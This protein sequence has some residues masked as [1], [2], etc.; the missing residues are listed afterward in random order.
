M[1]MGCK[2]CAKMRFWCATSKKY[3]SED[4]QNCESEDEPEPPSQGAE[5][6]WKAGVWQRLA[7]FLHLTA[8]GV[9]R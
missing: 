4:R 8:L 3:P 2:A 5:N 6:A 1:K 7:W 9:G